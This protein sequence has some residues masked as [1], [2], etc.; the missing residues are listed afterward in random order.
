MFYDL[1]YKVL[2]YIADTPIYNHICKWIINKVASNIGVTLVFYDPFDG[3][4]CTYFCSLADLKNTVERSGDGRP[5]SVVDIDMDEI[6]M[7][8]RMSSIHKEVHKETLLKV[9][10]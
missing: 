4:T 7:Y 3:D 6:G 9:I 1:F 8:F 5:W 10:K 2:N